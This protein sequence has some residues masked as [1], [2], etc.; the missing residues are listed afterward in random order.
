MAATGEKRSQIRFIA[1][2]SGSTGSLAITNAEVEDEA[3][4]YCGSWNSAGNQIHSDK[5]LWGSIDGQS[6][7]TQPPTSSVTPGGTIRLSCTTTHS[8]YCI[9]WYQQKPGEAPRYIQ[10]SG[11]GRGEGI[12][13]RF[14]ATSSGTTGTLTI[15]NVQAGDEAVYY[16]GID[17]QSTWTQPPSISVSPG[18]TITISCTTTQS[19]HSIYWYQ[20]KSGTAPRFVHC[21]GCNR[22]EGIPNRFTATRSGSTGTLTITN[23]Q[24][25]DEAVYYCDSWNSAVSQLHAGIDG[26]APWTQ[27]LSRSVSPGGTIAISCTTTQSTKSIY[28]FQQK[29]GEVP[30]YVHCSG[31][32][33]RGEGIPDRFTATRS[34]NTGTLTITNAQD[35][36]EADYYCGSW[37]SA[38]TMLHGGSSL[39][40]L[41]TLKGPEF[42]AAGRTITLSCRYDGGNLGDGNYPWWS[43]QIPGHQP[44]TLIYHTSSRPSGVPE[45]FSGSR[46][47]N[48]MS[49][50]ITGALVEDEATY[51]CCVWTGIDCQSTWIQ[52]PSISMLLGGTITPSCTKQSSYRI[53]WFQQKPEDAPCFVHTDGNDGRGEG[54]PDRFTAT[55]SGNTGSLTITDVQAEDEAD[56]YCGS[57]NSAD[58]VLHSG[59]FLWGSIEGQSTWTQ[60]PSI[61][62]SPGGTITISCTTTQSSYSID[63][64]QQKSGTAPRFVHCDGCSRG[65]GIPDR[66]TATRSG[67]T[68]SLAITNAQVEDEADYYCGLESQMILTQPSSMSA[69]PGLTFNIPCQMNTGYS[70]NSER[71]RWYQQKPGGIPRF[72]YHY[73]T[74][75]DQGRGT[76]VP[77]RFSVSP[78]ASKNLW[79]LVINGVQVEDDAVYYY[80][81]LQQLQSLKDPESVP[82]GGMVTISCRY[83]TGII[84]DGNYPWWAQK[85]PGK[86]PRLLVYQT[87]VKPSDVPVRFSGSN[88]QQLQSLRDPESVPLGGTVTISCRY[89]TVIADG[90]Y[91]WWAQQHPG[92]PPRLLFY[93]TNIKI[94]DVPAR[95][96]NVMSLTITGAL[97]EDEALY[98]SEARESSKALSCYQQHQAIWCPSPFHWD[99]LWEHYVPDHCRNI[100]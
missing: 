38:D 83:S 59:Q 10:C 6:S 28:W 31:C 2:R 78:D 62:V 77:E 15:T 86:P 63:W 88:L 69:S 55:R 13:D 18:G 58:T 85:L 22:G 90:N 16:C 76:G 27:P 96:G 93:N 67:S 34:G 99:H 51:Y 50:T 54:I 95:S 81:S 25:E 32:S 45:R 70:I 30:R 35:G 64:Y 8:S 49:L 57:W 94:S 48:V 97:A 72:L 75:T 46:S 65:E 4:Y 80:L 23:A 66:F 19:S 40:Q 60:P 91:P 56:Y 73:Y 9:A 100:G 29:P 5:F 37:N 52:R 71:A 84:A 3:D 11:Y 26:Q 68:G 92:K 33:N 7:W 14:T 87:S 1:T 74:S 17:G 36:D 61:S 89:S 24:V 43:Q 53:Y 44:R 47:G 21:D 12:P 82:L 79:N 39:Q 42:V 41:Q 20:Q 98:Y